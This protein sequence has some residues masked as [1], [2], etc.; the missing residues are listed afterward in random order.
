MSA[1]IFGKMLSLYR[2]YQ[3]PRRGKKTWYAFQWLV[4][5]K[6][7]KISFF[8]SLKIQKIFC[9]TKKSGIS[10]TFCSIQLKKNCQ[11]NFESPDTRFHSQ[12]LVF[13]AA[14]V[15]VIEG[16]IY[17]LTHSF[18]LS[19]FQGP[20]EKKGKKSQCN[21]VRKL[22]LFAGFFLFLRRTVRRP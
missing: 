14:V 19:L 5:K 7:V 1:D 10:Y 16:P 15:A 8:L 22:I 9:G 12:A 18:T 4:G 20:A 17:A 11:P 2:V 21:F 13:R 6:V 3:K